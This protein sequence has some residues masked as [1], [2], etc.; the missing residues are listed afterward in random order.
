MKNQ[1][2][3]F[4][5]LR[6]VGRSGRGKSFTVSITINTLPCLMATYNKAIKVTVDGPREP[7]AKSRMFPGNIKISNLI[8]SKLLKTLTF[9]CISYT[10]TDQIDSFQ[11]CSTRWA[12]SVPIRRPPPVGWIPHTYRTGKWCSDRKDWPTQASN[13]HIFRVRHQLYIIW[14]IIWFE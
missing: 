11:A 14:G 7:R 13:Y 9:D 5:D 10:F 12:C 1:V 6:F 8:K 2:A 3:K 4:S